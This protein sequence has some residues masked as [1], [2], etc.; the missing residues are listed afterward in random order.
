MIIAIIVNLIIGLTIGIATSLVEKEALLFIYVTIHLFGNFFIPLIIAS[1]LYFFIKKYFKQMSGLLGVVAY[2]ALLFIVI[3]A[4]LFFW[5]MLDV[6]VYNSGFENFTLKN[7]ISD[8][9]REFA[10]LLLVIIFSAIAI[11]VADILIKKRNL[12]KA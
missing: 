11:P 10:R 4:G 5:S 3:Q 8:Y 1:A 2:S 6:I 12:A 7:I 9:N